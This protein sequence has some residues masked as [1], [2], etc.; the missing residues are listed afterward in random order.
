METRSEVNRSEKKGFDALPEH[1]Q[2]GL[3]ASGVCLFFGT[4]N[5]LQEAMMKVPGF[6]Y[7][8]MLG[9][10]EVL[11]MTVCSFVERKYFALEKERI[12]PLSAYPLLTLCLMASSAF[13]N[14]ALNYINFPMKVVFRSSKLIPTMI[15]ASI[16]NKKVFS[17]VE[18][19]CAFS[20]CSGLILF[21]AADWT[22]SPSY[23][24]IGLALLFISVCADAIVP[25]AQERLFGMGAT[26]LEVT[27]YSNALT[28]ICMTTTTYLS[29]DLVGIISHAYRD[30]SLAFFMATYTAVAYVA[31]SCHMCVVKR[32]GGVA[33]VF[34]ATFRKALTLV[35]SFTM[36]P[37]AFSW[38]YVIGAL[39]VLG[40]LL[41]QSLY[42]IQMKQAQMLKNDKLS[43]CPSPVP[44]HRTGIKN[45]DDIERGPNSRGK[46]QIGPHS[47]VSQTKAVVS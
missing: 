39:L 3:L 43:P 21:A 31:I 4:H 46:Q 5:L 34:L 17:S 7:G 14:Q 25:N 19:L 47:E 38:M 15:V 1:V 16:L 20:V 30:Q 8:V 28:L 33:A 23:N 40:A 9:Y 22:L 2:F 10:M 37:K 13:S 29:G 27:F 36:F 24:P 32:F 26:R 41:L 11:G 42:K 45:S 12:A 6:N 44:E 18:Y 35:L